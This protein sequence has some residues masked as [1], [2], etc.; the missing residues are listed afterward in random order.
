MQGPKTKRWG[1]VRAVLWGFFGVRRRAAAGD[2]LAKTQPL[3]LIAVA[4]V[5]AAVFG[6]TF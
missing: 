2:G 5:L 4:V 3:V 6:L 1:Y